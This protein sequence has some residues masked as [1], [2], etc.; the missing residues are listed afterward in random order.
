MVLLMPEIPQAACATI[1]SSYAQI[2][3][4]TAVIG[5]STA[6]TIVIN[7][8]KVKA[9]AVL[10]GPGGF[11]LLGLY[12]VIVE[13][14]ANVAGL[15]VGNSGVRQI[16][17]AVASGDGDRIARTAFV[18]RRLALICGLS[19]AAA[20][21][22]L[23]VPLSVLTFGNDG[24]AGAIGILSL[25]VFFRVVT[26]GQAALVQGMRR[27]AD[28][29]A[30]GVLGA[31]FGA[32]TA[33]G[34]VYAVG[35]PG[36]SASIAAA[37]ALG[38]G[39]AWWY[40]GKIEIARPAMTPRQLRRE[41]AELVKLGAA[42]M[43]SSLL[44]I[45]ASYAV[46]AMVLHVEGLDGAGYYSAAWTL[47][48]LY[49]G[50]VLQAMG[51]DFYPRLVGAISTHAECNRL[52]NEQTRISLLLAGP[53]V[54]ATLTFATPVMSLFYS[55]SFVAAVD[56]LRWICLGVALRVITWPIG[57]IIVAKN[58]CLV[59][60]AAELAW[61]VV[62]VGLTWICVR[63]LG[64]EGTGIAF[65]GSYVFHGLMIYTIVRRLTGFGWS[66]ANV[67][68][69]ALFLLS[70]GI[71]FAALHVLPTVPALAFGSAATFVSSAIS[72]R[73]LVTIVPLE[74]GARRF[75]ICPQGAAAIR[76][77]RRLL[78]WR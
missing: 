62:N 56:V 48:G 69:G 21:A 44:T 63:R 16:A 38:F 59:F 46:R 78:S 23:A 30:L 37:A 50:I 27:V 20:T 61:T 55:T 54:I 1:K 4:S 64:L 36:V 71:V 13:L 11:G 10:L 67:R 34:I 8:V 14:A 70:I 41:A 17:D 72:L 31:L 15:G 42:F 73:V 5:S 28:L 25:A 43:A 6:A 2:L 9:I 60:V 65:F 53:G 45:G 3:R 76:L 33:V 77:A 32:V 24:H 40:V 51:A 35:E 57:F 29:A 22:V 74:R 12:T 26:A 39:A 58:N 52:V 68:T 49:V 47:G 18:L 66:A 75:P 19:G 7:I